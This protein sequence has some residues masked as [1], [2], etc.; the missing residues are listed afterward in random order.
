MLVELGDSPS[1]FTIYPGGQSGNPGSFYYNDMVTD[2]ADGK[3]YSS[4][5]LKKADEKN[6]QIIAKQKI[7]K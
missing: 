4:L 3:Y 5:F 1:A 2:W 6:D 7:R